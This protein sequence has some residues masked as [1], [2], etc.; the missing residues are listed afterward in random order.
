MLVLG[1]RQKDVCVLTSKR[2]RQREEAKGGS[3][4]TAAW[5]RTGLSEAE[6]C[7]GIGCCARGLGQ[8]SSSA[9]GFVVC[10]MVSKW[11]WQFFVKSSC[12]FRAKLRAS[13]LCVPF[14][15]F[16]MLQ[17]NC[18]R[19]LVGL[20]FTLVLRECCSLI[21]CNRRIPLLRFLPTIKI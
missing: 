11:A 17:R 19:A 1:G 14:I 15:T 10:K 16:Q 4:Q 5:T 6:T 20:V 8:A 9:S 13:A 18:T 21:D 3:K 7:V 2:G 12:L